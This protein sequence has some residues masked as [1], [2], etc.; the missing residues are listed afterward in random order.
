MLSCF[1]D[2]WL[3]KCESWIGDWLLLKYVW[4]HFINVCLCFYIDGIWI[5]VVFLWNLNEKWENCGCWWKM[6]TVVILVK[7]GVM[8][9]YLWLFWM[10]FDVYKL[11]CKFWGRI[12]DQGDQKWGF[13][14]EN[15]MFPRENNQNRATVLEKFRCSELNSL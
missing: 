2:F 5:G 14:V 13:W 15:W 10:P 8:I 12:W 1:V 9:R 3:I 11:V 7:I 4:I 6:N